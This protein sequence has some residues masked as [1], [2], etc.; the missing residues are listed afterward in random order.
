MIKTSVRMATMPTISVRLLCAEFKKVPIPPVCPMISTPMMAS[1]PIEMPT[2]EP[3]RMAGIE[4][5][6]R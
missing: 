5:G 1:Q 6:M 4:S 3:V 2:I